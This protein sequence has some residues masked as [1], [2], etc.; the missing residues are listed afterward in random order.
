MEVD[1]TNVIASGATS[2]AAVAAIA[3]WRA[4][5]NANSTSKSLAVVEEERR[6]AELRPQF[7]VWCEPY[8]ETIFYLNLLLDGP[9][10]LDQIDSFKVSIRNNKNIEP[11]P[12]VIPVRDSEGH[13]TDEELQNQ[14][15]APFRFS[16]NVSSS[17][18]AG[19]SSEDGRGIPYSTLKL[20]DEARFQMERTPCP[21]WNKGGGDKWWQ[22]QGIK[23]LLKILIEC[24]NVDLKPWAVPF[25]LET[26]LEKIG[27][28]NA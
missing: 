7:K 25:R 23:P 17:Q 13:P 26:P 9:D 10:G 8:S 20:G 11:D 2:V 15:W 21:H 1:W 22:G 14:I 24:Q 28:A 3:S 12:L 5:V 27:E 6:H 16:P 4:A 19:K 18:L